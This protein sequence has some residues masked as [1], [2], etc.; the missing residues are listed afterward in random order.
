MRKALRCGIAL[1][2]VNAVGCIAPRPATYDP[3]AA[4]AAIESVM[5][6][7]WHVDTADREQY[8]D[9]YFR[10][11]ARIATFDLVG[12]TPAL[13]PWTDREG[14]EHR[15]RVGTESVTVWLTPGEYEPPFPLPFLFFP[16]APPALV[17]RSKGL[18]VYG[19]EGWH[20]DA[21]VISHAAAA[22]ATRLGPVDVRPSWT[23]WKSDL[24]QR[25]GKWPP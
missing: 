20:G 22:G 12:P 16:P 2:L 23:T 11:D 24:S 15:D 10:G 14:I 21:S 17:F 5:P 4:R 1:L 9:G 6:S 8:D 3:G 18:R 7:G 25:L 13:Y 19:V